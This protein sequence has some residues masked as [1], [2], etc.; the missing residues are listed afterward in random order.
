MLT[1]PRNILKQKFLAFLNSLVDLILEAVLVAVYIL[2]VYLISLLI[3]HTLG[4]KWTEVA[5][6]VT[7]GALIIVGALGA[8]QF[9]V[10]TAVHN[11]KNLKKELK[12]EHERNH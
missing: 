3:K 4:E 12:N 6:T 5:D 7:H 1:I 11:Y 9:I 10:K 8:L 2:A